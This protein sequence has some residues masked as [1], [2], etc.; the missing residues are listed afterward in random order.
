VGK[1]A[2]HDSFCTVWVVARQFYGLK[3]AQALRLAREAAN[4]ASC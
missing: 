3:P 4:A 1:Q 2:A